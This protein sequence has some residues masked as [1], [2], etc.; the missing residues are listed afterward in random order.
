MGPAILDLIRHQR[1]TLAAR[2]ARQFVTAPGVAVWRDPQRVDR[3]TAQGMDAVVDAAT[4]GRVEPFVEFAARFTQEALALH[5]PLDEVIR[6]LLQVK[7]VVLAFLDEGAQPPGLDPQTVEFMNRLLSAGVLEAIRRHEH[8]RDR[9]SLAVQ[10]QIDDL[11]ERLRRQALV[12]PVTGLFNANYFAVAV[13]REV[14]RSRRFGRTFTIGL[15]TL[16]EDDE[17]REAL[18][19]DGLRA[20]MTLLAEVLTGATRQVDVR[21]ALGG[22]RF[23]IILPETTVEGAMV[24][25]ERVRQTVETR[26]FALPDR[27]SPLTQTVSIGLAAYPRDG[28]DDQTLLA[29]AEEALARARAGGNTIVAAATAQDF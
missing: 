25:A 18:G 6:A 9:R 28:D 13:R 7:P 1:R 26:P 16:D 2:W 22:G 5:V 24:F 15:I 10:E 23:A 11:R 21:A 27:P 4:T 29:R 8:Q 14:Q 20:V 17:I 19:D 3:A 12:D